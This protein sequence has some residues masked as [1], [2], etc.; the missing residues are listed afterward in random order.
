M[1]T[2]DGVTVT[3]RDLQRLLSLS[4][5]A[6]SVEEQIGRTNARGQRERQ[7]GHRAISH[8]PAVSGCGRGE[9]EV[10]L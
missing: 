5:S 1:E 8:C 10:V 7:R 3:A 9:G 2:T 4:S 6:V